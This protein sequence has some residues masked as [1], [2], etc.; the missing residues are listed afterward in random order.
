[1][2]ECVPLSPTDRFYDKVK[3]Y[4]RHRMSDLGLRIGDAALYDTKYGP[5]SPLPIFM[6]GWWRGSWIRERRLWDGKLDKPWLLTVSVLAELFDSNPEEI[7][8]IPSIEIE[9][10]ASKLGYM[11][12]K[13]IKTGEES[14]KEKREYGHLSDYIL[15]ALEVIEVIT[16]RIRDLV[17][18]KPSLET[19]LNFWVIGAVLS[20]RNVSKVTVISDSVDLEIP[21]SSVE[22][23]LPYGINIQGSSSITSTLYVIAHAMVHRGIDEDQLLEHFNIQTVCALWI[24]EN[25]HK[26]MIKKGLE[27]LKHGFEKLLKKSKWELELEDLGIDDPEAFFHEVSKKLAEIVTNVSTAF[28]TIQDKP[29]EI[30]RNLLSV[31]EEIRLGDEV[32]PPEEYD[33]KWRQ[34]QR[35]KQHVKGTLE[36]IDTEKLAE[37]ALKTVG[38]LVGGSKGEEMAETAAKL[39]TEVVKRGLDMVSESS[40][41]RKERSVLGELIEAVVKEVMDGARKRK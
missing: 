9:P 14:L 2:P 21:K 16:R 26:K 27:E 32:I 23:P 6:D 11:L 35:V 7:A 10:G 13:M 17:L 30:A 36:S 34:S 19:A 29:E 25:M 20:S 33:P 22:I 1:M 28:E 24:E 37:D 40:G 15:W 39:A 4:V 12:R 31:D 8:G 3:S 38:R 18:D 5:L 41:N